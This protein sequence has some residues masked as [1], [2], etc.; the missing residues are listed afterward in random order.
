MG[1]NLGS[2]F[3][4]LGN[5]MNNNAP[6][7]VSLNLQKNDILDLTKRNPGL[8]AVKLAAGWDV[9]Q[10]GQDFDLDIAA[11]LLDAN[12]KFNTVSNVIFFN[13]KNGQGISLRGD[14]RT[15]AGDGD[16]EIID[17]NLSQISPEIMKIVF[18]VTISNAMQKRQTF[19]MVNNSYVRLLDAA[20]GDRE[21]CRFNLRE[22]GSTATSVIFAELFR[23]GGE[24]Q[25]RAIGDGKIADLNGVLALFQ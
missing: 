21:V 9:A 22:D 6:M 11:F 23:D 10:N 5:N 24:W 18:V 2:G 25:F 19:G 12:N 8:T 15:G 13:N 14:N 7:G 16:D 20:N 4:N 3:E 17:I 1:I